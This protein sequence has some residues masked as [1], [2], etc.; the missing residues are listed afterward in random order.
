MATA[1]SVVTTTWVD[2]TTSSLARL[3]PDHVLDPH[4]VERAPDE[5]QRD[6]EERPCEHQAQRGTAPGGQR[7]RQLDGEQAKQRRKLDDRIHSD[8][9]GVL[10]RIADR[11]AHNRGGVQLRAFLLQ[12]GLD[13][14]LR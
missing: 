2:V 6:D 3:G 9:G 13:D 8:R 4:R 10:E 11:I 1:P 5:R 14:L 12:L 7:Y